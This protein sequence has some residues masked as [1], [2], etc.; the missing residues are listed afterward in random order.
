MK[1]K[2]GQESLDLRKFLSV[3]NTVK[4][5]FILAIFLAFILAK[6][7]THANSQAINLSHDFNNYD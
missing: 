7:N 3:K 2:M 1:I 4:L 6:S 5:R